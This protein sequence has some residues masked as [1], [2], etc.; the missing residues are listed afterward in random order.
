VSSEQQVRALFACGVKK[1]EVFKAQ[2]E[3]LA[4]AYSCLKHAETTIEPIDD[5]RRYLDEL[6]AAILKDANAQ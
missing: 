3:A 1:A 2:C 4:I 5:L 6:E